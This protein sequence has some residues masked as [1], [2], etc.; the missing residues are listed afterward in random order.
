MS[1]FLPFDEALAMAQSLQLANRREWLAWCKNGMRPP[2][3]PA[4]PLK[5]YTHGGWQGW[6]HWLG[7]GNVKGGTKQFLPFGE[8]VAGARSLGLSS[9][10]ARRAWCNTGARPENMP[11]NPDIAYKHDGWRG[12]RHWLRAVAASPS[13]AFP[14]CR[15]SPTQAR[16][17]RQPPWC[18]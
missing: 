2:N 15:A 8:A 12:Y 18:V 17:D 6:G 4:D 16:G 3:V 9:S 11:T 1:K 14:S 7:T 5:A 13:A 10:T